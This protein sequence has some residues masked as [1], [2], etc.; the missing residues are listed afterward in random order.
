MIQMQPQLFGALNTSQ[1]LR[2]ALQ[3]ALR[4]EHATIPPYLYTMYSLDATVNPRAVNLIRGIAMEEMA[5]FAIA[6]NLLNAIGGTPEIDSPAFPMRYPGPLPGAVHTSLLVS[7][8]AFS[9]DHVRDV[10][11]EIERPENPFEFRTRAFD[12]TQFKTIGDFYRAIRA[13]IIDGGSAMVTGPPERQISSAD[14][15]LPNVIPITDVDTAVRAID[16]VVEQGEGTQDGPTDDHD[17]LAHYYRFREIVEG[18][19]LIRNAAA[20][21]DASPEQ[22]FVYGG[23]PIVIDATGILPVRTN[24]RA[25][26]F[27][28]DVR[29]QIDAFNAAYTRMLGQ[30]H[31]GFRGQRNELS[32]AIATMSNELQPRAE[33]LTAIRLA[34]GTAAAPTFEYF[35]AN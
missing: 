33:A 22:R 4:L 19:E 21:P 6:C 16:H 23:T 29:V 18:W 2:D 25:A 17:R 13:Q 20:P 31:R 28:A 8:A 14:I 30:L 3:T 32:A 5:H 15:G 26:D 35:P 9:K 24:P 11:M 7:L 1:G 27:P 34:D 10:F 12:E